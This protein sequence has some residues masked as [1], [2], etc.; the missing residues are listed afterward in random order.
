[1]ESRTV[2]KVMDWE[3]MVVRIFLAQQSVA[4]HPHSDQ[5][6]GYVGGKMAA[7]VGLQTSFAALLVGTTMVSLVAGR[8]QMVAAGMIAAAAAA[9]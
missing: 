5:G 6:V 3:D 9:G 4:N 7:A 1:M 8:D 2:G